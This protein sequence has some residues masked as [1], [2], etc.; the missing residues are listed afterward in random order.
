M[1]ARLGLAQTLAAL[2]LAGEAEQHDRA[3]LQ[4]N[5]NDHQGVR[6]V[7]LAGLVRAGRD[8][9]TMALLRQYEDGQ[10]RSLREQ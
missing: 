2:N 9:E 10:G 4:L 7:L 3:L 5:P 6:Y 8:D 1:R